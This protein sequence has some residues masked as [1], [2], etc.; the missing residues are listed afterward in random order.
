MNKVI[1]VT[2][3][4]LTAFSSQSFGYLIECK[5]LMN[6]Y[7]EVRFIQQVDEL[8]ILARVQTRTETGGFNATL[9]M[10]GADVQRRESIPYQIKWQN[11]D[12]K[13]ELNI[14]QERIEEDHNIRPFGYKSKLYFSGNQLGTT[15][16]DNEEYVC[17]YFAF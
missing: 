8:P 10:N 1:M 4:L 2:F 5:S 12:L 17:R 13:I 6:K 14:S 11:S 3:F 7:N 16:I 15:I 9:K